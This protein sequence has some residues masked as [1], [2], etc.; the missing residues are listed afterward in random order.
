MAA[1]LLR[2]VLNASLPC[3]SGME[4]GRQWRGGAGHARSAAAVG[5]GELQCWH[6]G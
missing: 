5:C 1:Q 6:G 2:A 3:P 4:E